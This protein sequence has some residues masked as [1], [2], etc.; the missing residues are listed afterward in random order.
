MAHTLYSF[1]AFTRRYKGKIDQ[2]AFVRNKMWEPIATKMFLKPCFIYDKQVIFDKWKSLISP[3]VIHVSTGLL[4]IL[5]V[6]AGNMCLAVIVI[7]SYPI[8]GA[9]KHYAVMWNLATAG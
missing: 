1:Y 3:K 5:R 4:L 7:I 6:S 8:V 2:L 9:W